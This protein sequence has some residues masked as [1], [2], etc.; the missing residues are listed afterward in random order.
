MTLWHNVY[1]ISISD[2]ALL[3]FTAS[4]MLQS[5]HFSLFSGM[6]VDYRAVLMAHLLYYRP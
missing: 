6:V 3:S 5:N 4:H 2:S 1:H